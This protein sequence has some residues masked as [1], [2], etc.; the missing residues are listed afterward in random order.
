MSYDIVTERIVEN[1]VYRNKMENNFSNVYLRCHV[2]RCRIFLE[3]VET[4]PIKREVKGKSVFKPNQ[5]NT[6]D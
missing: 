2:P 3:Q 5:T 1:Q 4:L 6:E